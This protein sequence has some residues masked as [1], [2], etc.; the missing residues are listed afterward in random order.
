MYT[1]KYIYTHK[2]ICTCMHIYIYIYIYW[3]AKHCRRPLKNHIW[4][5]MY[6]IWYMICDIWSIDLL[7]YEHTERTHRE[8]KRTHCTHTEHKKLPEC[9]PKS[10]KNRPKT[11]NWL[12]EIK[13]I[14]QRY[15]DMWNG[16]RIQYA[17]P[18]KGRRIHMLGR[19][20]FLKRISVVCTQ[21]M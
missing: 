18:L 9:M 4:Y 5:M 11:D 1:Y 2:Y 14:K 16:D 17:R 20:V 13:E 6:D 8:P 12:V 3:C 21:F 10:S 19:C 7:I 15:E